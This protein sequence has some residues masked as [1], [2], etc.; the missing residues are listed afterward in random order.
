M[1]LFRF[2]R[3]FA[4]LLKVLWPSSTL[5]QHLT[6]MSTLHTGSEYDPFE[7]VLCKV[8][9][10]YPKGHYKEK[11]LTREYKDGSLYAYVDQVNN[12]RYPPKVCEEIREGFFDVRTVEVTEAGHPI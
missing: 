12:R 9:L 7:G 10:T 8:H 6:R 3:E 4:V 5:L 1:R 11:W 2:F